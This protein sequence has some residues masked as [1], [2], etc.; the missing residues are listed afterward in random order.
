MRFSTT[1]NCLT[2]KYL[3]HFECPRMITK[4]FVILVAWIILTPL[5]YKE[6]FPGI[7]PAASTS[8]LPSWGLPSIKGGFR[9]PP[10]WNW[11]PHTSSLPNVWTR[12]NKTKLIA[13]GLN[14]GCPV[15]IFKE[16]CVVI[17]GFWTI[18]NL[19]NYFDP[20]E[21][22]WPPPHNSSS[23]SLLPSIKGGFRFPSRWN[24]PLHNSCLP[25]VWAMK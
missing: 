4:W 22:L 21:L 16:N 23:W 19:M 14:S 18:L 25:I 6:P 7:L 9:F 13:R 1:K 3:H 11:P 5:G 2:N 8:N 15:K 17:F 12:K 20:I 24:R 10:R